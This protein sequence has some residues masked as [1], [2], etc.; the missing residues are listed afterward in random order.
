MW[1]LKILAIMLISVGLNAANS[2]AQNKMIGHIKYIKKTVPKVTPAKLMIWIENDKDFILLDVR[3]PDELSSG[4]IDA[5]EYVK[6]SRGKL[7]FAAIKSGALPQDKI[8]VVYCKAGSRGALATQL[9]KNYGYKKTYNLKGGMDG[10]LDAGYP[11]E[12]SLGTFRKVP[13][14]ELD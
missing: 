11:I 8:I 5:G 12:T 13:E 4:Y 7:E 14:S 3:D 2:P 6:I 9:L 10:W 1:I